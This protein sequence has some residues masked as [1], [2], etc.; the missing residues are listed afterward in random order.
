MRET[1]TITKE[2]AGNQALLSHALCFDPIN[3]QQIPGGDFRLHF[4]EFA[5]VPGIRILEDGGVEVTFYAPGAKTVQIQG[6]GGSFE[7]IYDLEPVETMTGYWRTTLTGLMSGFHYHWYLV[8]GVKTFH[9]TIPF[10]YG[11]SY[12]MNYFELPDPEFTDY[13][14]KDVPHGSLHMELY[15]S[16]VTGRE[17]NCW[18]YTPPGYTEDTGK[19]YPV[20]YLQHGG[21]ENETG[22]IWQGK[23]NYILDNLIA[24]NKCR[25]MILVM[26]CGYNF[27]SRGD[28]TFVLEDIPEVICRDCVPMIDKRYRTIPKKEYRAMAGLSF[29]SVHARMTVL[30]NTDVFSSLGIFSGGF[31]YKTTGARGEGNLGV[32]DY[33]EIFRSPETFQEHLKLL[34]VGMGSLETDMIEGCRER[35]EELQRAGIEIEHHLYEG[36]HEWNVWRKCAYDMAQKLFRW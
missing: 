33:S 22:W 2:L 11:C 32:Y 28:G 4:R 36:Y 25:E 8:D 29:G 18:V 30:G 34:F 1:M 13:L 27:Q 15:H 6:L 10:G 3:Q 26:N 35:L 12:V 17:R 7:G 31:D 19:R 16:E 21:G 24:Q 9:P 5:T 14:L 20:F 23:I